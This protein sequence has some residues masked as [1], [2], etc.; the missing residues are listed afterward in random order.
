ME[1]IITYNMNKSDLIEAL[2]E[3]QSSEIES[4][5]LNKF[6]NVLVGTNVVAEI[7]NVSEKTVLNYVNDGLIEC[8]PR[9]GKKFQFRLSHVLKI[10]FGQLKRQL[11]RKTP[12]KLT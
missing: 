1:T 9:T 12:T 8:E 6:Y 4:K 3:V 7:H 5:I 2:H 10:D 11:R